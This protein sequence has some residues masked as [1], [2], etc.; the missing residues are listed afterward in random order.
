MTTREFRVYDD[1]RGDEL[2]GGALRIERQVVPESL[3]GLRGLIHPGDPR[4]VERFQRDTPM[5]DLL[6]EVGPGKGAFLCAMAA[7][8]PERLAVGFEVRLAFCARTL[9]RAERAGLPNLRVVWGDARAAIPILLRPGSV[10]DAYLLYPDPW[11]KRGHAGRR[12]GSR[13]AGLLLDCLVPGG[14]VVLKSDVPA[15]LDELVR[16]FRQ[17]GPFEP[18]APPPDLP[19]TDREA[20][21]ARTG[22]KGFAAALIK[23]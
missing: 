8:F 4:D 14:L 21:L 1:V 13:L 23:R 20:K 5:R 3:R 6:V 16:V 17:A 11:W 9:R 12:Y 18:C 10:R 19:P 2:I 7:R 15:Y 22:G